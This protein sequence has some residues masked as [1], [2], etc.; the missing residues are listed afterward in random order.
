MGAC[1]AKRNCVAKALADHCGQEVHGVKCKTLNYL[2]G[3]K[4]KALK[5]KACVEFVV[6]TKNRAMHLKS[7]S[8][9]IFGTHH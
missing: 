3:A 8:H 5:L 7:P 9:F 1:G 6:A 4:K 2:S